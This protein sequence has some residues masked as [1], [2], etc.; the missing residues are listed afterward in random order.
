VLYD[1]LATSFA[2]V[3][4]QLFVW[5]S[6]R[7]M[8]EHILSKLIEDGQLTPMI[9]GLLHVSRCGALART[10]SIP[11]FGRQAKFRALWRISTRF[12]LT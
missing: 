9:R 6:K 12:R 2:L 8:I 7:G 3:L 11:R 10:S 5:I 4:I 1:V